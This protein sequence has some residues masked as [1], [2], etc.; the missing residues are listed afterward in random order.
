MSR[1]TKAMAKARTRDSYQALEKLTAVVD[2]RRRIVSD[3]PLVVPLSD[4]LPDREQRDVHD[5]LHEL[6]RRYRASLQ[7]DR[8]HLLEQF[9]MVD[10][11]HKVVGVGESHR[12]WI[13]LLLGVVDGDDPLFR[14]PR[15]RGR[16]CLPRSTSA[17]ASGRTTANGSWP[18]NTSCRRPATSSSAGSV[19]TGLDG[20]KWDFDLGDSASR[21]EGTS[22]TQKNHYPRRPHQVRRSVRKDARALHM[23]APAT[24]SPSPPTWGR[25][26]RSTRRS[27]VRRDLC[28]PEPARRYEALGRSLSPTAASTPNP[29]LE[30]G[31]DPVSGRWRGGARRSVGRRRRRC[32]RW[33]RRR[34]DR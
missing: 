9:E 18:A 27:G 16:R 23:L 7:P 34:G 21:P 32:R 15:R 2:G 3:P 33:R 5:E 11:A 25:A 14:K 30:P 10:L 22:L 31:L 29:R 13:V 17:A 28:G 19:W 12:S 24:V 8:R 20:V 1:A 6:L 26:R 4:L